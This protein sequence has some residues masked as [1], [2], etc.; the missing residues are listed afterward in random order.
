MRVL[1]VI[2]ARGG[3]KGL[4]GK[5]VRPLAG[6]PLI[7]HTVRCARE[8]RS[9]ARAIVT[10]DDPGIAGVAK[11]YGADVP[12]LR[13]DELARDDTPM[14]PVIRHALEAVEA[15]E[16]EPYDAVL[17]LD[18]T[19]PGRDPA[20]IEQAV[21]MLG[22]RPEI[23]GVVSVSAPRF[24]PLW[25][26]VETGADGVLHRYFPEA[27]GITRRQDTRRTYLRVN[28]SFYLWRADYVRALSSSWLDEGTFAAF[29]I[30]ENEAF[31]I[32]D[33]EEFRLVEALASAGVLRLPEAGDVA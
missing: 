6:V 17:L 4:P 12:F 5:N 16:G 28:G 2:P 8:L 27:A 20:K 19:S 1:A 15:E 18:P 24:D 13:P 10:T 33:E 11:E 29:E 25:V 21:G 30:P 32:D 7:G 26:G 14:A 3:S 22:E 9:V 23:D 31:S